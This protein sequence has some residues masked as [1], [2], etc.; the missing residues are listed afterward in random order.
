MSTQLTV[1]LCWNESLG[2][3]KT[4]DEKKIRSYAHCYHSKDTEQQKTVK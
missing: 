2:D 3:P 1:S 4:C